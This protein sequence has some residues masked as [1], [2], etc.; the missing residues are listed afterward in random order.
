MG[1]VMTK[2]VEGINY[3]NWRNIPILN[4][5]QSVAFGEYAS[6]FEINSKA[7]ADIRSR[8]GKEVSIEDLKT[9]TDEAKRLI[10][11]L[12]NCAR[13][14]N[15]WNVPKDIAQEPILFFNP[16]KPGLYKWLKKR[17]F[18]DAYAHEAFAPG[19]E[20]KGADTAA[21]LAIISAGLYNDLDLT[22]FSKEPLLG[23]NRELDL[24]K[25]MVRVTLLNSP[26]KILYMGNHEETADIEKVLSGNSFIPRECVDVVN[27]NKITDT[28]SQVNQLHTYLRSNTQYKRV[29]TVV[30][31]AQAAR[32]LNMY[33]YFDAIPAGMEL[34]IFP[35]PIPDIGLGVYER[36][37]IAGLHAR[38]YLGQAGDYFAPFKMPW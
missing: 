22:A 31:S 29:V 1:F 11:M 18:P 19:I 7:Q 17:K 14:T 2:L 28:V 23:F 30:T 5:K 9:V 25:D 13:S 36:N 20:R 34:Y 24:Q 8:Q 15:I 27:P 10:I 4:C 3:S 21:Q 16:S 26:H 12:D 35:L 37:E 33:E 38:R 6:S 32:I